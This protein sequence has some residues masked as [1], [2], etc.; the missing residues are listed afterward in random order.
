LPHRR[1]ISGRAGFRQVDAGNMVHA[2]DANGIVILTQIEP[3]AVVF[4]LPE[5]NLPTVLS[6]LRDR[7]ELPV[8]AYDRAG[9]TR[10]ASGRVLTI[11]NRI[12]PSTGT[13][14]L[15]ALFENHDQTLFPEQFVNARMLAETRHAQVVIRTAA[16]QRGTNG[17]FVYAINPDRSVELRQV[18]L[19]IENGDETAIVSGLGVGDHVVL[20]G[21]DRLRSGAQVDVRAPAAAAAP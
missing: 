2:A 13:F 21:T 18:T 1:P 19:G 4:T 9:R 20:D 11:D 5:D 7:A 6:R 8:D 12:D 16:V 3:I 10:L 17:T 15:K 14:R